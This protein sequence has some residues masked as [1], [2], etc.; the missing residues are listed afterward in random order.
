MRVFDVADNKLTNDKVFAENFAPGFTDG[1]RTNIDGNVSGFR[2]NPP[3]PDQG[4]NAPQNLPIFGARARV[5]GGNA[6]ILV[7]ANPLSR[8][9][10]SI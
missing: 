4:N 6:T 7:S 8:S 3:Y 1:V 2:N 9:S 10:R 5:S